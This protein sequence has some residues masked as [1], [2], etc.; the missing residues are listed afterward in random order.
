M[1]WTSWEHLSAL[2]KG[3]YLPWDTILFLWNCC[4]FQK[5]PWCWECRILVHRNCKEEEYY[6][7]RWV[8]LWS[9]WPSQG[10]QLYCHRHRSASLPHLLLSSSCQTFYPLDH[11]KWPDWI[12]HQSQSF[13]NIDE[14]W[15]CVVPVW[16]EVAAQTLFYQCQLSWSF[17][18]VPH[19]Y[20]MIEYLHWLHQLNIP[21][22]W[23][24][25]H[26]C[27]WSAFSLTCSPYPLFG[28]SILVQN[29]QW[30]RFR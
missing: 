13:Q 3:I 6:R 2:F 22:N 11:L 16:T 23:L 14:D 28:H 8:E 21:S 1:S 18:R 26:P 4:L 29:Y 7:C 9:I 17:W 12:V 19:K 30:Y 25:F 15:S 27:P 24:R 5:Y 10:Y 20:T